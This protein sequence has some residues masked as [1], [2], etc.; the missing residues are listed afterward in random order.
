MKFSL[1]NSLNKRYQGI[2][3]FRKML[4]NL[5]ASSSS[6]SKK[7]GISEIQLSNLRQS[8]LFKPGIHWKSSPGGQMK[9]WNPEAV[10]NINLCIKV[11]KNNQNAQFDEAA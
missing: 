6:A 5:W 9:P 8:G 10:Y 4:G 3:I 7:L 1:S 11:I 2:I